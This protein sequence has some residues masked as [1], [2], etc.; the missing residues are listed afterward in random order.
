MRSRRD[1]VHL[2]GSSGSHLSTALHQSINLMRCA[3]SPLRE[4]FDE[5]TAFSVLSDL[6]ARSAITGLK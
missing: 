3:D 5:D 2:G 6:K 1:I 4:A